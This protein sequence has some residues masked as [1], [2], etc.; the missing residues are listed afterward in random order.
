MRIALGKTENG[1]GDFGLLFGERVFSVV[2][3]DDT[4]TFRE[5]CDGYFFEEMPK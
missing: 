2:C 3:D 5:G 1:C 4:V